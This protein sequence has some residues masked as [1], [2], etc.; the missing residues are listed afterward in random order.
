MQ[1]DGGEV[2]ILYFSG[3]GNSRYAAEFLADRLD[4]TLLD[5]G[6]EIKA[7]HSLHAEGE[8]PLVVVAPTYGWQ[9]PHVLRDWLLAGTY[10]GR[11]EVYFVL[12][13][14]S[15]IGNAG[16]S[17]A[18]LSRAKGL[19]YRGVAGVVMPENYIAM[20]SAPWPKEAAQI[21]R[22]AE[23]VLEEVAARIL[24]GEDLAPQKADGTDRL[25][26]G[27]VNRAFY[28]LF[29]KA[30]AFSVRDRCVGC[31]RCAE[32]CP[33]NNISLRG[34]RPVWGKHCTHCM[35]CICGCPAA[36]VEYGRKSLGKPRYQCPPYEKRGN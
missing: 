25:K 22:A 10:S 27:I 24:A 17:A 19:R 14:G 32:L 34:G 7:G 23:P 35:A 30:D 31:G 21:V 29:V 16:E 15:D 12:T 11:G 1:R 4:D 5:A 8:K 18:S 13:C 9:M 26:S 20:F 33:L 3:T 6:A 36:A 2:M 28:S